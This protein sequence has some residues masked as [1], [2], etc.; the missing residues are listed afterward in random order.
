MGRTCKQCGNKL[1]EDANYCDECGSKCEN[2]CATDS[3]E[4]LENFAQVV[5]EGTT[6]VG[7]VITREIEKGKEKLNEFQNMS[8]EEKKQRANE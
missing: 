7:T 5:S 4:K 8:K 1:S 2:S 6:K 3:R